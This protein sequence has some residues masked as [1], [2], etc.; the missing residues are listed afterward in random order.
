MSYIEAI[1]NAGATVHENNSFGDWQGTWLAY[2][3]YNGQT[4][5]VVGSYG[6]CSGCDAFEAEFGWS[7]DK[8]CDDHRYDAQVDCAACQKTASDYLD[9]L[10]K[11][12][13][14]YLDNI[15]SIE[16]VK[17]RFVDQSE[18]D[19]DAVNVIKWLDNLERK[20]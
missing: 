16:D 12:G 9:K 15:Q 2:I 19:T 20:G 10:I 4:G 17:A 18:W 7:Y 1:E 13:E 3:T 5:I 11:F 8:G 6:S 14:S